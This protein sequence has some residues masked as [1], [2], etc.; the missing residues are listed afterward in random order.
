MT[1]LRSA[2][3]RAPQS[4]EAATALLARFAEVD[5]TI[6]MLEARRAAGHARIDGRIDPKVVPLAAEL[7]DIAKQL[8]PWWEA[9]SEELTQGKRRSIELGGC[10]IGIRLSPPK[11]THGHAK[12]GDAAL[13]LQG[14]AYAAGATKV[15]YTL[16][17]PAILR[18]LEEE[19]KAE[20]APTPV[21]GEPAPPPKLAGLGFAAKQADEFFVD[22]L[23]GATSG[24]TQR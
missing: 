13:A 5:A 9:N 2:A 18:I 14:T 16:D 19:A 7:K 11:V 17:K 23:K 12:D 22:R 6:E 24:E 21:E 1:R 10:Q 8:K 20:P 3:Q 4:L 15:T